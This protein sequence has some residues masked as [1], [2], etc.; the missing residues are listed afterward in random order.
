M[1]KEVQQLRFQ[2]NSVLLLNRYWYCLS[3]CLYHVI[4]WKY[5]W[6]VI[7]YS[8]RLQWQHFYTTDT[9]STSGNVWYALL[10][11]DM[12]CHVM[13]CFATFLL[14]MPICQWHNAV[15]IRRSEDKI[16]MQ[17]WQSTTNDTKLPSFGSSRVV[18]CGNPHSN[19]ILKFSLLPNVVVVIIIL[20]D[21]IVV[22]IYAVAYG[23]QPHR[24][25]SPKG[26][27]VTCDCLM[28]F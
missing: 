20:V 28:F 6:K 8:V 27:R 14:G 7:L 26:H 10:C 13:P 11:Y 23:Q 1:I 4:P 3:A 17:Y 19:I 15:L 12:T 18:R 25:V 24:G 16:P 5:L 2:K 21:F 9:S 22:V